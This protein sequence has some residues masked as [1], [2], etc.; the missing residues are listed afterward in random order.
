[1]NKL[2]EFLNIAVRS[3]VSSM[4][5]MSEEGMERKRS[6]EERNLVMREAHRVEQEI[7]LRI[8]QRKRFRRDLDYNYR[9]WMCE[10]ESLY[11]STHW[12]ALGQTLDAAQL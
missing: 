3:W 10:P 6:D 2:G 9:I 7:K 1:M 4:E 11:F 12:E 5:E 8:P